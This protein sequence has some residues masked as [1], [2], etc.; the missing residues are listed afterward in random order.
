M[1]NLLVAAAPT[2]FGDEASIAKLPDPPWLEHQLLESPWAAIAC[3]IGFGVILMWVFRRIEK[4]KWAWPAMGGALVLAVGIYISS[5]SVTTTREMLIEQTKTLVNSAAI[6]DD[7]S[8][9]T[10]LGEPLAFTV[11]GQATNATT[12][13]VL[14]FV[15]NDLTTRYKLKE[16]S[17]VSTAATVDGGNVA[18][19]QVRVRV[20][21]EA[22]GYPNSSWWIIH[23]RKAGDTG[24]WRVSQIEAQHIQ[25]AKPGFNFG[26]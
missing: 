21:P 13:R 22:I 8:V 26:L 16:H 19:S 3:L 11:L 24:L 23:W 10:L 6:G 9:A 14:A 25:G 17:V 20:V 2:L 7:K 18:R 12:A 5:E 15:R 4:P 1:I